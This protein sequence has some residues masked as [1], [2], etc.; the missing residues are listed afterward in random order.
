VLAPLAVSVVLPPV[1]IEDE[2]TLIEGTA[3]TFTE[4]VEAAEPQELETVM[5]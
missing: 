2:F 4:T 1:H 3:L 5:E